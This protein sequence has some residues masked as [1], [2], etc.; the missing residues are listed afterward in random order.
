MKY[1]IAIQKIE[2]N[3]FFLNRGCFV[4]QLEE[5]C[6]CICF[7][8]VIIIYSFLNYRL[9]CYFNGNKF[10][11]LYLENKRDYECCYYI[12]DGKGQNWLFC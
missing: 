7:C 1:I 8:R 4:L 2:S 3:R 6:I 11:F 10:D 5:E 12:C 9:K